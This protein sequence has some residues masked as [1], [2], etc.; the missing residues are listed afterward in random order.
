MLSLGFPIRSSGIATGNDVVP[1]QCPALPRDYGFQLPDVLSRHGLFVLSIEAGA[2][3]TGGAL[4][5]TGEW[6]AASHPDGD[7][8]LLDGRGV[9]GD[10]VDVIIAS[11]KLEG[12]PAPKTGQDLQGFIQH[13]RAPGNSGF[14]GEVG[15]TDIR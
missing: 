2:I 14:F 12:F 15:E 9:K 13:A 7:A 4:G 8:W 10:F 6:K 5:G 3:P 11:G 1:G